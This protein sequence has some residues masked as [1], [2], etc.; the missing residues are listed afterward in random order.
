MAE[1]R[2]LVLFGPGAPG[3]P[4]ALRSDLHRGC[5]RLGNYQDITFTTGGTGS[6]AG[7]A[8]S[9]RALTNQLTRLP[10]SSRP[11]PGCDGCST[12]TRP[13]AEGVA[14]PHRELRSVCDLGRRRQRTSR[15][16]SCRSRRPRRGRALGPSHRRR[17][18]TCFVMA[19]GCQLRSAPYSYDWIDNLGKQS[20]QQ[21]TPGLDQPAVGQ[22]VL[23]I[24]R[25]VSF[26]RGGAPDRHARFDVPTRCSIRDGVCHHA[27]RAVGEPPCRA[28]SCRGSPR[29]PKRAR[30]VLLALL[31]P[32][33]LI[34]TRRQLRNLEATGRTRRTTSVVR[35]CLTGRPSEALAN[36][37]SR[38]PEPRAK[39]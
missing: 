21:L 18:A 37:G 29:T 34:M 1:A 35:G 3:R 22:A 20:P 15:T 12:R 2:H 9:P 6:S 5:E 25:I 14:S 16:V 30:R 33:D 19:L 4:D 17:R 31:A 23:R 11:R 27:A 13:A 28:R 32:M 36:P 39:M 38:P 24:F 8:I 7:N 26:A 10:P